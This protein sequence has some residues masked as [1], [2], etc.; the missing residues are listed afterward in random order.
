MIRLM[1][2][3]MIKC[4][5]KCG[6]RGILNTNEPLSLPLRQFVYRSPSAEPDR[7][8]YK[9]KFE[10][11]LKGTAIVSSSRNLGHKLNVIEI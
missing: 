1:I 3:L 5:G 7:I 6:E 8:R 9:N 11:C 10:L 4:G 2:R